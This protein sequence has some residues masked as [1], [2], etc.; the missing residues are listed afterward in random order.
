MRGV[1]GGEAGGCQ[2]V[3]SDAEDAG[4]DGVCGRALRKYYDK[5]MATGVNLFSIQDARNLIRYGGMRPGA[6]FYRLMRAPP[7]RPIQA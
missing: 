2:A 4:H 5:A 7:P 1:Q 3:T 6:L